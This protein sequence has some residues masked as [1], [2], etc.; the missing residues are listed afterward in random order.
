MDLIGFEKNKEIAGRQSLVIPTFGIHPWNAP[1]FADKLDELE[2]ALDESV[3]IGEIGLDY[4][5][6]KDKSQYKHQMKVFEFFLNEAKKKDKLVIVHTKGAEDDVLKMLHQYKIQRA[7]IH[8]YS[9]AIET[10][11]KM[12]QSDYKFSIG[13]MVKNSSLIQTIAKQMP[14]E[15][16]LT[17]T[18]NPGGY[19]SY[20][21]KPGMPS[22]IKD[23]LNKIAELRECSNEEIESLVW[24]NFLNIL[25]ENERQMIVKSHVK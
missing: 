8:W 6:V 5:F 13:F 20:H 14:I 7:I 24:K 15:H 16:L 1:H 22:L 11:E 21:K 12:I 23:V 2:R 4:Y 19:G 10:Y 17:E 3:F 18:D 25:T 9:G